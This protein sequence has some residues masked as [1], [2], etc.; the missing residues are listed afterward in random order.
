[1]ISPQTGKAVQAVQPINIPKDS[2]VSWKKPVVAQVAANLPSKGRVEKG[3]VTYA[4]D[5]DGAFIKSRS[6]E[7]LNCRIEGIDAPETDKTKHGKKGAQPHAND[8]LNTLKKMIVNK[9]VTVTVTEEASGKN[10]NRSMCKIEIEGKDV[11][12]EML[13]AGAAMIYEQFYK[14]PKHREAQNQAK[15]GKQGIWGDKT[16]PQPPWE[17]RRSP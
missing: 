1:V 7:Q 15:V 10:Y 17:Y 5:G 9:E 13:R 11:S 4:L 2:D 14:G 6:G 16:P 3:V 12:T 8:S